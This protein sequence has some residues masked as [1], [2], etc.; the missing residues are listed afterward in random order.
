VRTRADA[1]LTA[2]LVVVLAFLLLPIVAVFA[3][4]GPGELWAALG[5]GAVGDAL[6]VSL[7][8]NAIALALVLGFGTPAAF[9]VAR[10][11]PLRPLVVALIEVPLV[12]PPAVAGLGLLYA[13]G[14][15]G[16]FG[17]A[18]A[19]AGLRVP[20]T[21]TAV[22]LA[23]AYVSSPFYIRAAVSAFEGVDRGLVDAA[24]TLGASPFRVFRTVVLPLS[25]GSLGAGATL[26]LARGLG[27]FGATIVF[28]G[29]LRGTTQTLPLAIYGELD[30]DPTSALAIGAVLILVSLAILVASKLV[31][32]WRR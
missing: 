28:A 32:A 1:G 17:G 31:L 22:V 4:V 8:T 7:K 26:A 5:S 16:L 23:V 21:Q 3:A 24:R 25:A 30:R 6:L 15:Q 2:A 19:D 29:S 27:E 14:S 11:V 20:L 13:F 18:L 10:G 12:L 9:L